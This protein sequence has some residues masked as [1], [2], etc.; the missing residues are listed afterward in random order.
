MSQGAIRGRFGIFIAGI[1]ARP[2]YLYLI[3]KNFHIVI[4]V[5]FTVYKC[6]YHFIEVVE[7]WNKGITPMGN[8]TPSKTARQK[9][10]PDRNWTCDLRQLA[11]TLYQWA[12][13][14]MLA[15][16]ML[17]CKPRPFC[18]RGSRWSDKARHL[19]HLSLVR[20]STHFVQTSGTYLL[21]VKVQLRSFIIALPS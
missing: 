6:T 7:T 1:I 17:Q 20:S 10:D 5:F 19:K 3:T 18:T 9:S 21:I 15:C 13:R 16:N 12:T 8:N 14:P 11:H 4:A 2:F